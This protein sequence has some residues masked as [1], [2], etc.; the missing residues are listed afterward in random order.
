MFPQLVLVGLILLEVADPIEIE[1]VS[2]IGVENSCGKSE[3]YY[4]L[5]KYCFQL[6]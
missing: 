2:E 3:L 1:N 4:R 6:L 5:P